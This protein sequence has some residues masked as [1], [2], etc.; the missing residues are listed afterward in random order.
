MNLLPQGLRP[1]KICTD[2]PVTWTYDCITPLFDIPISKAAVDLQQD[3]GM[4][5]LPNG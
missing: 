4:L 3:S 5:C 1:H 2:N